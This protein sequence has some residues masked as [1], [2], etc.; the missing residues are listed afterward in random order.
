MNAY[1]CRDRRE[2]TDGPWI[3]QHTYD[4]I[5]GWCYWSCGCRVDGRVIKN[6]TGDVIYPGTGLSEAD[7]PKFAAWAQAEND[8]QRAEAL[9]RGK[10]HHLNRRAA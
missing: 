5:S 9:A 7:K 1:D 6:K 4:P 2:S 3:N 8:K 10:A